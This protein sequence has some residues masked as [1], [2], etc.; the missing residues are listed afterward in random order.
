M[1]GALQATTPVAANARITSRRVVRRSLGV[2]SPPVVPHRRGLPRSR[3]A[4]CR[5]R[6][7][8][9]MIPTRRVGWAC[10]SAPFLPGTEERV[11]D[12]SVRWRSRL[13]PLFADSADACSPKWW[14]W[15]APAVRRHHCPWE[16]CAGA[17]Q[18]ERL[19]AAYL[20]DDD[21]VR[22]HRQHEY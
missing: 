10:G 2:T 7:K 20:A 15:H 5:E 17:A 4:R 8:H 21:P 14:S 11:T 13:P 1:T 16:E 19:G 22:A 3:H 6:F 12:R 9:S 18:L